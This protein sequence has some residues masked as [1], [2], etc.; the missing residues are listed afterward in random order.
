MQTHL[1]MM[2]S[3]CLKLADHIGCVDAAVGID[4]ALSSLETPDEQRRRAAIEAFEAQGVAG[5]SAEETP[6]S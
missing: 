5:N 3:D 1:K 2:L 4:R 6:V